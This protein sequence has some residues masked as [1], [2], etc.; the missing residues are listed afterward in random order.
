MVADEGTKTLIIA[1]RN[2]EAGASAK[3]IKFLAKSSAAA[4]DLVLKIWPRSGSEIGYKIPIAI[5]QEKIQPFPPSPTTTNGVQKAGWLR[6]VWVLSFMIE[7]IDSQNASGLPTVFSLAIVSHI[8]VIS[9]WERTGKYK[10]RS[11]IEPA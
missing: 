5:T 10:T 4:G 2:L 6:C 11:A 7:S 8:H 9:V 1:A 3:S